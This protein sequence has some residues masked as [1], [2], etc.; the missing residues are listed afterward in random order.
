MRD[1]N[2]ILSAVLPAYLNIM[3]REIRTEFGAPRWGKTDSTSPATLA[4]EL[5]K[6]RTG[7]HGS[8]VA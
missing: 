5:N 6:D 1:D 7:K 2:P 3:E 4:S 8:E